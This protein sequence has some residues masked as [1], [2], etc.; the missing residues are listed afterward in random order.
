MESLGVGRR[1]EYWYR[2]TSTPVF[3]IES[4]GNTVY[5]CTVTTHLLI[6]IETVLYRT[7]HGIIAVALVSYMVVRGVAVYYLRAGDVE[8]LSHGGTVGHVDG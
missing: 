5:A 7:R 3:T 8:I 2:Y 4:N 6:P 1:E